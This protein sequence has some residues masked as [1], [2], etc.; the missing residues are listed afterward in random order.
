M[1]Q[2][3]TSTINFR[4]KFVM[5]IYTDGCI[6]NHGTVV[7]WSL[8]DDVTMKHFRGKI[9]Y[10]KANKKHELPLQIIL[11]MWQTIRPVKL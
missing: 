5:V 1:R 7:R 10:F 8:Y 9:W 11:N 6:Y 4:E 3:G 2:L